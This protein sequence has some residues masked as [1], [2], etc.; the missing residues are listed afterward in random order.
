MR[1]TPET[2]D[3]LLHH[4]SDSAEAPWM[5][6]GP[7]GLEPC[8]P[9]NVEECD[10][11]WLSWVEH[12]LVELGASLGAWRADRKRLDASERCCP[13]CGHTLVQCYDD[14][15]THGRACCPDCNHAAGAFAASLP[16][17]DD[18]SA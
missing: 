15:R 9:E 17:K 5:K 4:I 6:P 3:A 12:E 14:T 11:L 13:G 7:A 1:E 18:P 16:P 2:M 8:P 10:A